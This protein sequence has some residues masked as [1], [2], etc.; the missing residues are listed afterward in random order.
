MLLHDPPG[1]PITNL[2]PA[3]KAVLDAAPSCVS[4]SL[5]VFLETAFTQ[6]QGEHSI[7]ELSQAVEECLE[8][9]WLC[10]LQEPET[11]APGGDEEAEVTQYG[12]LLTT[13]GEEVKNEELK[14][15]VLAESV[16]LAAL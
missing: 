12:I 5:P 15:R 6:A 1:P 16:N 14:D 7:E 2:T 13:R 3:Q 10:L 9:N 4:I 8:N 11:V